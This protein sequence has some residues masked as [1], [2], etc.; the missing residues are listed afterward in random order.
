MDLIQL[1]ITGFAIV[2]I[3]LVGVSAIIPSLL[4]YPPRWGR[5]LPP[6]GRDQDDPDTP[7][8]TPIHSR[9]RRHHAERH[10][11]AA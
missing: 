10:D 8:P 9:H 3:L 2:G 4:D 11:L 7:A 6:M 5:A 1:F